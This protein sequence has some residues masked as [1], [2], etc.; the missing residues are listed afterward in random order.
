MSQGGISEALR[1]RQTHTPSP[2]HHSKPPCSASA[3]STQACAIRPDQLDP[4]RSLRR[5]N[6]EAAEEN[7][8]PPGLPRRPLPNPPVSRH[9]QALIP[10]CAD[11]YPWGHA[12]RR[13][14]RPSAPTDQRRRS[15]PPSTSCRRATSATLASDENAS[16]R[17][18][19]RCSSLQRR[20]RPENTVICPVRRSKVRK[21]EHSKDRSLTCHARRVPPDRCP[22]PALVGTSI[23]RT[24]LVQRYPAESS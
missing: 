5:E 23:C 9:H 8:R 1:Y 22:L 18:C 14:T 17:I 16:V 21:Q 2:R 13:G 20:R 19:S 6:V 3:P 12:L 7:L 10:T 11:Q 24:P 15:A 4:I